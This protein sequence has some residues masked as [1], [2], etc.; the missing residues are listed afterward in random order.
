LISNQKSNEINIIHEFSP[1]KTKELAESSVVSRD[2]VNGINNLIK[3][4]DTQKY[5]EINE[6]NKVMPNVSS[7]CKDN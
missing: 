7:E 1:E 6:E 3:S 5:S 4:A 2:Y